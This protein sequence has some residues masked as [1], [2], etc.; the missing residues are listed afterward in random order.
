[1]SA[2]L[3]TA[4]MNLHVGCYDPEKGARRYSSTM[5]QPVEVSVEVPMTVPNRADIL[6]LFDSSYDDGQILELEFVNGT[7]RF[8]Q[9]MITVYAAKRVPSPVSSTL[10]TNK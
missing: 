6:K 9:P 10:Q 7:N 2:Q 5:M 3:P 1:M 4:K 8:K